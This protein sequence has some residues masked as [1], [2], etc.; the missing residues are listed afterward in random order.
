MKEK[1]VVNTRQDRDGDTWQG[2]VTPNHKA[3][4]GG[5]R[6]VERLVDKM[7]LLQGPPPTEVGFID[8]A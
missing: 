5:E 3:V 6:P 2:R 4:V 1:G 7:K 8:Y